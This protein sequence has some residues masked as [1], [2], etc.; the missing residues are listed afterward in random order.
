[1]KM[2][3]PSSV[4]K[5]LTNKYFLYF[6]LFLAVTNVLGYMVTG[7][8]AAILFFA[9]VAYI[10]HRFNKNMAIVLGVALFVTSF[11]MIGKRVKEGLENQRKKQ[12]RY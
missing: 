2:K 10:T 5:I 11:L 12:E 1:M 9:M 7:N 4:S 8:F 3:I 6:V